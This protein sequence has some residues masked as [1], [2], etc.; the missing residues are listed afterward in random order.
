MLE[1]RREIPG[2][3]IALLNKIP[4]H[5]PGR[6]EKTT[7]DTKNAII[8]VAFTRRPRL[9]INLFVKT[10]YLSLIIFYSDKQTYQYTW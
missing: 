8:K 10:R 5:T 2:E 4:V 7:Q 3:L 6:K 1:R 9:L